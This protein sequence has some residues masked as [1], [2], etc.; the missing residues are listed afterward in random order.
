M[1]TIIHNGRIIDGNGG[2]V[3]E[4][5]LIAFDH[6]VIIFA[7]AAEDYEVNGDEI[8]ID[9]QGETI[10]PGF[11]DCHVHVMLE[12]SPV[13]NRL[14]TPFSYT[15]YQAKQ[16]LEKTLNAGI[17]S[18]RDAHG[19]DLGV[20]KA[21]EDRLICGPRIQISVEALTITGGIGDG[22]TNSGQPV[23]LLL[24]GYP[25][26]PDGRCDGVIEVRKKT[27]EM[28]RAGAEVIKVF[29]TG[30][31]LSTTDSPESSQFSVEE[32]EVIVA[33]ARERKGVNVMAHAHGAQGIKNAVIAGAHSIEHGVFIDDE[34]IELMVKQGT[35]LVPTL[36]ASVSILELAEQTGMPKSAVEKTN[37]II[38]VHRRNIA[39]AYQAGVK[40]AMGTDAGVMAHGKNLRE[41][42][43]MTGIGM[44]PMEAIVASTKTAAECMGWQDKLGTLS[45]GKFADLV[46]VK[47]NPLTDI[48]LLANPDNVLMVI[49]NGIIEKDQLNHNEVN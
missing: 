19:A 6:E 1:K 10:L 7:G 39:K 35:Y 40:I 32:L 3:I 20:K 2:A 5:G 30:G 38:K 24:S 37:E 26:K 9:A 21:V 15:F 13:Q 47:G 14:E 17:T 45:R 16:Y 33:E 46:I 42:E 43:L 29:A 18:V 28:L 11:I 27:R 44:S 12:Y 22:Y 8:V 4:K 36:Y 48:G 49:K 34:A 25:G 23:E 41:L 31:V